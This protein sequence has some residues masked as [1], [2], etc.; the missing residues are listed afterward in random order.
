MNL[1]R[2][3]TL[4]TELEDEK[5]LRELQR[6]IDRDLKIFQPSPQNVDGMS[7]YTKIQLLIKFE[8]RLE[9]YLNYISQII[10][11]LYDMEVN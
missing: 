4:K 11:S 7:D 1:Y 10:E 5:L 8:G 6:V 9:N 2:T 3:I